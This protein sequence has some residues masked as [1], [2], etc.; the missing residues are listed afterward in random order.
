MCIRDRLVTAGPGIVNINV[1]ITNNPGG[2]SNVTHIG[3]GTLNL[4]GTSTYTGETNVVGGTL[5]VSSTGAINTTS[6]VN[7]VGG[8]FR[9]DNFATPLTAPVNLISGR[10]DGY[11]TAESVT[12]SNSASA[13]VANRTD[14][15]AP[16]TINN[17]VFQGTGTLAP[18]LGS[19]LVSGTPVDNLPLAIGNLTTNP[20]A[21]KVL[22]SPVSPTGSWADGSN[23]YN[24]LTFTNWSGS[25]SDFEIGTASPAFAARQA[26]TL[27][28]DGN[29]IKITVSGDKALWTGGANSNWTTNTVGAPFNWRTQTGGVD[30]EFI[31]NDEVVF[32]DTA[33]NT[34]VVISDANVT[35]ANLFVNN[36][37]KNYSITGAPGL[38]ISAVGSFIKTGAGSLTLGGNNTYSGNTTITEGTL[39]A[40]SYTHLRAHETLS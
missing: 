33:V 17:L 38:G 23:T 7:V 31:T 34:N 13:I 10:M 22:I 14:S 25:L 26:A 8:T 39:I 32:D 29:T 20:S 21:G 3:T 18:K 28:L 35:A 2:A 15:P 40:V 24:L 4:A 19:T 5:A 9:Q 30:T 16:L 6:A 12:V 27:S 11:G 1:P 36:P 37:T